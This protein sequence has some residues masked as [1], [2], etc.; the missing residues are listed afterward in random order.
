MQG[1]PLD[2][3]RVLDFSQVVA[4]PY[5]T[6]LLGWLGAE[7]VRIESARRPRPTPPH[8]ADTLNCSK[9]SCSLDLTSQEGR[10]LAI[11]LVQCS[12]VVVE[13]FSPR[14]MRRFG[15]DYPALRQVKPDLVMISMSAFGQTGPDRDYVG[16][17]PGFMAYTG[18]MHMTGFPEGPPMLGGTVSY[19]DLVSGL[20][21]VFAILSALHYRGR[22]GKGQYID[23][24]QAE[25]AATVVAEAVV[26][27]TI[28][29]KSPI[30][31]GNRDNAL[32]P[33]GCYRCKGEDSWVT[34]AVNTDEEWQ[35]MCL[36]MGHPEWTSSDKFADS[37]SRWKNQDELDQLVQSW[38]SQRTHYEVMKL[39][40][41]A[42]VPAGPSLNAQELLNDSHLQERGAFIT[43]TKPGAPQRAMAGLPW[44]ANG[45]T[46]MYHRAPLVGEDN[47]YLLGQLLGIPP[48]QIEQLV[49]ARVLY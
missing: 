8:L 30:R 36:V 48:V 13:N 14:T 16:L 37:L 2:G 15:L 45:S 18:W 42:G 47:E 49:S 17:A 26:E 23:L 3:V 44:N 32:A 7:V 12:D 1:H 41:E 40:Q 9:K 10:D 24:A 19:N 4:G 34:I 28:T 29:G 20:Y 27:H 25:V 5:T 21:A 22:T 6:M 31:R 43:T 39:L 38:T 11:Q 33:H 35:A 46:P